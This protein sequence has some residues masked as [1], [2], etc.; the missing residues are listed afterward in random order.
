[1]TSAIKPEPRSWSS[2]RGHI[3]AATAE[4]FR[5]Q[6]DQAVEQTA[7]RSVI[8]DLSGVSSVDSSTCG[9]LLGLHDRLRDLG[10]S[11]VLAG[12]TPSVQVV[13]DSI[14]LTTFFEI[15]ETVDGALLH[16]A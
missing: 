10:G 2:P 13:I 3:R 15:C 11:A 8:V 5:D 1:M 9:Y 16:L 6:V 12:L 4:Q 14:G 7:A